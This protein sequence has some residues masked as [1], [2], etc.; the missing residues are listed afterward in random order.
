MQNSDFPYFETAQTENGGREIVI[1][2]ALINGV[3]VTR[4]IYIPENQGF[5]RFLEI[6]HNPGSE[7]VSYTVPIY[8]NLG[9]DGSE[10]FVYTSSGDSLVTMDDDW[11]ITDDQDG[12][13]DPT[14]TH[15]VAGQGGRQRSSFFNRDGDD[16]EYKYDLILEPGET[17]IVMHFASQA[18][19]Q[20]VALERAPRLASLDSELDPLSG[21]TSIELSQVVNFNVGDAIDQFQFFAEDGALLVIE[22]STPVD[23]TGEPVNGLNPRLELYNPNGDLII[24]DD[25]SAGDGKNARIEYTVPEE[26]EGTYRIRIL[27]EGGTSGTYILTIDGATTTPEPLMVT[28]ANPEDSSHLAIYPA[29]YRLD[30]SSPVLFTSVDGSDLKVNDISADSVI[31]VDA[32]TLEFSISS[33]QSGD[34]PYTV[35][36]QEGAFVSI[37]GGPVLGFSST[38]YYDA[39]PPTIMDSSVEEGEILE[40]GD[41]TLAFTISEDLAESGLGAEDVLLA[42]IANGRSYNPSSFI[43][44]SETD[45]VTVQYANLTEGN[46]ELTLISGE[47]A[48]RDVAGNPLNGDTSDP[49]P[50]DFILHFNMDAPIASLPTLNPTNPLGSLV[51]ESEVS[52]RALHN[53]GDEDLFTISLDPGQTLSVVVLPTYGDV[54]IALEVFDPEG[55]SLGYSE[56]EAGGRVVLL[57]TIPINTF[58]TYEIVVKSLEGIGEYWLGVLLNAAVES[59]IFGGPSNDTMGTAEDLNGSFITIGSDRAA[60]VGQ[61]FSET[62]SGSLPFFSG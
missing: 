9:S 43:Y 22:T 50:D 16:I 29:T 37:S 19:N 47:S 5:A 38:F 4:K 32:D 56:A 51:Y 59:E 36:I 53:T 18:P 15:V 30:L 33:S 34:G 24:S 41:L 11:V 39:T 57:Q 27:A 13:W 49:E 17:K 8:T 7:T 6:V 26:G 20:A 61:R 23:G 40:P 55:G 31:L 46:Y 54:R 62:E 45:I 10:S 3:E 1:G 2:P 35:T 42:N 60:V 25:D 48:F 21:M 28:S 58:G 12:I 14:V 52:E 44:D